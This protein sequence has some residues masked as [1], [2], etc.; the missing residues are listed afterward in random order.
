MSDLD[1]WNEISVYNFIISSFLFFARKGTGYYKYVHM[2][3]FTYPICIDQNN[4]LNEM[5]AASAGDFRH[6]CF[7][8]LYVCGIRRETGPSGRKPGAA[9]GLQG[10]Q[11]GTFPQGGD[12]ALQCGG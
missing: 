1:D 11:S 7:V 5:K 8:R 6:L 4:R 3:D 10:G 9:G 12:G 2:N